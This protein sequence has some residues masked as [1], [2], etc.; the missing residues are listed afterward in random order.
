[1]IIPPRRRLACIGLCLLLP[2]AASSVNPLTAKEKE[3]SAAAAPPAPM[4]QLWSEP[5]DIASRDL[6]F[7]PGGGGRVPS[8]GVE[9]RF[10]SL[11]KTGH[12][13]GYEVVDP[14]GI[15]WKVKIGDEAQPEIVVS[16]ILWA[17]GY[18][19]PVLY[20]VSKWRLAGGPTTS[21]GPG[22][23]RLE[24][25]HDTSGPWPWTENPF[26][27]T[28]PLHGL[29]VADTLLNNWDL[30][31]SNNRVYQVKE[32]G[33]GTSTW[34]VDQDVGCALGRT[35][36]LLG[37]RNDVEG[38]ESQSF[39]DGTKKGRVNFDYHARHGRLLKDVTPEDVVWTCRLLARLTDRQLDDAFRA[40]GYPDAVSRRYISKIKQ[41]IQ[42]GLDL[43]AKSGTER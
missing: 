1:M 14:N 34:Y 40:A 15:Q 16:R 24:S 21:P 26:A 20:Y 33:G 42:E 31:D 39:I 38:F 37:S 5:D 12:S 27:G 22:R 41:K 7:G 8:P 17:I 18:H 6:Y 32:A 2:S 30:T 28:P 3:R 4:S 23:F 11:D 10:K 36:W 25:D 35:S 9:Y 19:Q 43:E 29:L 13:K